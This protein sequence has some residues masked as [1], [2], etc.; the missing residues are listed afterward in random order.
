MYNTSRLCHKWMAPAKEQRDSIITEVGPGGPA[1]P[2]P[3]GYS[4]EQE[5]SSGRNSCCKSPFLVSFSALPYQFCAY[6]CCAQRSH[7]L[8]QNRVK[9]TIVRHAGVVDNVIN[10]KSNFSIMILAHLEHTTHVYINSFGLPTSGLRGQPMR[11][12]SAS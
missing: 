9:I 1:T 4:W 2:K 10:A 5:Q 3:G 6:K 7:V 11:M 8:R 12:V